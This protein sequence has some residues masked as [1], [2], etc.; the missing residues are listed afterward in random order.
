[1][2]RVTGNAPPEFRR[3][4]ANPQ[5]LLVSSLGLGIYPEVEKY[6]EIKAMLG[7][8]TAFQGAPADPATD[9]ILIRN[10]DNLN[11][12]RDRIESRVNAI[13][14]LTGSALDSLLMRMRNGQVDAWLA[15]LAEGVRDNQRRSGDPTSSRA[16]FA[17]LISKGLLTDNTVLVHGNGLEADDFTAMRSAP[18]IR[19]DG[20]GDGLGAKLVWSPLSNLLLYG[21][22]TLIYP[23]LS[24]GADGFA[25]H[26]LESERFTQSS[27]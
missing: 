6:A 18:S 5:T 9:N 2:E 14:E 15:H 25:R 19:R 12:G 7:G 24:L 22:T 8:E 10:V 17:A 1:M 23:A 4:V 26:G 27:R 16:E 11:F 13:A 20:T 21:Q 3:L